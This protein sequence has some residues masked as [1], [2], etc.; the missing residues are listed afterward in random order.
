MRRVCVYVLA[1]IYLAPG[2]I[3]QRALFENDLYDF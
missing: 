1:G 2:F 3:L